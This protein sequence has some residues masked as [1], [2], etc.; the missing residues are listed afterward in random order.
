MIVLLCFSKIGTDWFQHTRNVSRLGFL[1]SPPRL[2]V[3][4]CLSFMGLSW[5]C[6]TGKALKGFDSSGKILKGY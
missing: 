3:M 5:S 2:T 1:T 4:T 6:Q